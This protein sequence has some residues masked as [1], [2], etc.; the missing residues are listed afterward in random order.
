MLIHCLLQEALLSLVGGGLLI[1]VGVIT[2]E[3]YD[4]PEYGSP[5]GKALSG[6]CISCGVV[7]LIN[8]LFTFQAI[9]EQR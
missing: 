8:L 3:S 5:A 2:L 1:G 7:F 4:H 6:L 9:R